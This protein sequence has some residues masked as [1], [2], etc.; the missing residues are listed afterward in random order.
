M[1]TNINN[2]EN[3][4]LDRFNSLSN[5]EIREG[6]SWYRDA[7]NFCLEVSK[8]TRTELFIVVGVLS[9]L[10]PRNKWHRNKVD[11]IELIKRGKRG[12]YATFN[13]NRDKAL[14]ILN[15]NS[16]GEVKGILNGRKI[17]SFFNNIV[18]PTVNSTVTIDVW[19]FRTV[20]LEHKNKNYSIAEQAYKNVANKLGIKA[21]NLQAMLWTNIRSAS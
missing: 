14:K 6:M 15:A 3:M 11:T 17:T 12:K 2:L 5:E 9:A 18:Y 1:E 21:H 20:E 8:H 13:A 19:A 10:S 7:H 4:L 16:I